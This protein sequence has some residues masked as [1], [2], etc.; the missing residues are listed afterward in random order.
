MRRCGNK[1]KA[2]WLS[3]LVLLIAVA[4]TTLVFTDILN[5]FL[6]NADGAISLIPD[7]SSSSGGQGSA[8]NKPTTHPD[9]EVFDDKTVW[10]TNT[11]ID[12]FKVTYQNDLGIT[13]SSADG[14]KLLAPGLGNTYV[15][16]LKNP[17][18][19]AMDFTIE[20]N[21][22]FPD[23]D[24]EL[25]ITARISRYDG[26]WVTGYKDRYADV[27]TLDQASDAA[28][29]GAGRFV[30]Y[31]LEW[32]WPRESGNDAF[33]TM[34][35]ELANGQDIPFRIE[36]STTATESAN[37]DDNS[38]IKSPPDDNSGPLLWI[39][40]GGGLALILLFIIFVRRDDE[41]RDVYSGVDGF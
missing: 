17:G 38:G 26:T 39:I 41:D 9:F 1:G 20:F 19:V 35:G 31:S 6:P 16:K 3:V 22:Y 13:A 34:L 7:G 36:I 5:I 14:D 37:P 32:I 40:L 23:S 8:S 15:V 11:Q 29:V 24:I 21:A 2:I 25:P 4:L 33:D 18:D 27:A 10:T 12:I 28:T 30:F